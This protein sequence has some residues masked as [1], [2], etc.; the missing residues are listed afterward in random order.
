MSD[1]Q[2]NLTAQPEEFAPF[3]AEVKPLLARHYEELSL[4]KSRYPLNP[5]YDEYLRRDALGMVMC[6]TLR[7]RGE[8][9]GYFVGFVAPGLHYK[10]C[11]TLTMDIF[12]L[13]P[14]HRGNMGGVRLFR[15]VE[16][17]AKRRGVN[18]IM[19][20]SKDHKDS[21]RLFKALGYQQVETYHA[22]WID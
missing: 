16:R 5:Q 4:H 3:L 12:W 8:L 19:N 1:R 17:E 2:I 13:A 15:T 21:S 10:D 14:E 18:L 22:K 20:G 7:A 11:L 9:V 6:V